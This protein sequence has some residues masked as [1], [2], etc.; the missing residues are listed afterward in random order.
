MKP[1]LTSWTLVALVAAGSFVHS[2]T[3]TQT[4]K[5]T[6]AAAV[7]L[8]PTIRCPVGGLT[9][10][11]AALVKSALTG[12]T[13]QSY[14]CDP[15]KVEQAA[16]GTC[17]KCKAALQV[18]ERPLLASVATAPEEASIALGLNLR[19]RT[20]LIQIE[21]ALMKNGVKLDDQTLTLPGRLLL[22]LDGGRADQIATAKK[23]LDDAHLFAEVGAGTFDTATSKLH[24]AVRS[25]ATPPTRAKLIQAIEPHKLHLADVLFVAEPL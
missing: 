18:A 9:R 6:E 21:N 10:E 11:N 20:S 23:A 12:L 8:G 4:P 13:G 7:V 16:I 5:A 1:N 15:C 25:L 24:F 22:V 14:V 19:R 17:S 3:P 2:Q